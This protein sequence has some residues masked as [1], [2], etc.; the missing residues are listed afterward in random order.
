M[1]VYLFKDIMASGG[2]NRLTKEKVIE[3]FIEVHGYD[4]DYSNMVYVNTHTPVE[5]RCK[6]HD[7]VFFPTPRNHKN[8]AKCTMC[9]REAQS[10]KSSKGKEQFEK[11]VFEK[12]G[13][14]FDL[15]LSEYVNNKTPIK[16]IC[17]YNGLMEI[18]PD[19]LLA[20]DKY[21]PKGRKK[22]K[23]TDKETFIKE[24]IKVYGDKDD[25]TGTNII[26]S[27]EKIE[28]RCKEHDII[29]TKDIQTYLKG[30]GCPQCSAENYRKIRKKSTEDYIERAKKV[31]GDNCDYTNTVYIT[32]KDKIEVKC[33]IHNE[34]FNVLP[35]NHI[36]GNSCKKCSRDN[37]SKSLLGKE[38]TGGYTKSGYVNQA[39]GRE[40]FVYLIKC[41]NEEEEFYKIGKTF[42][43]INKRFTKGNLCYFFD[44]IHFHFG[45]AG[46]IYDLENDLHKKYK[47]YKYKPLN[48]FAGH[49]ECYITD[50]PIQEII[51]LGCR[52]I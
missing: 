37:I 32:G 21:T 49:T 10:Q 19:S 42:L 23:S 33:N 38:G 12:Y 17:K 14:R 22:T 51:N 27:K 24:A 28:V 52:N 39:N 26:S 11:E 45:E 35:R 5:V 4:F 16:V 15:S 6:K 20:K 9:G 34:V 40:A 43:D 3:Q 2:Q 29:F 50:L 31:H 25:Y 18:R 44:S 8:G 1:E 48:W 36:A 46:Y 7:F 47:S 30:W 13:D 41:W